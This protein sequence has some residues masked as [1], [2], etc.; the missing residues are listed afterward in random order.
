MGRLI[1]F[2]KRGTGLSDRVSPE[3]LPDLETRMDDVR[4]VL[5]A[6]G[7]RRAVVLGFSEGGSMSTLFAATHP[8]RTHALVLVGTFP[9]MMR[10]PD[11][12]I[13]HTEDVYRQ[14]FAGLDRD[15]WAQSVTK[16][17]LGRVAPDLVSDEDA[18]RWY[19]SYVMRGAS[20]AAVG[21]LWRMNQQIDIRG[22][23][24]TIAVPTLVAFRAQEYF[25]ERTRFMGEHIPGARVVELP[26]NDH[27][28]WEGDQVKLLDEVERFLSGVEE[29]V[30]PNRVLATLLFTD[31]VGSTRKA[32]ELGDRAWQ[33]LLTMHHRVVRAQLAR[34]RGHEV[35]MAGDG[36]FA[37]FDGPARAVRC[38]AAIRDGLAG[39]E[40][41]IRAGIHTGE[42]EQAD[43]GVR[44][45]AVHIA[46]RISAEA[47]GGEVLVSSTVKDIVAGSGIEFEER[48]ER[49]LHGVP[50]TWR[51]FTA[52]TPTS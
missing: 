36:V 19:I 24:P 26:G 6:V 17:W 15:D 25:G 45:I 21:A 39:L 18:V 50:G 42:I 8:D 41:E 38:A 5:D 33:E 16:E 48:G 40:L 46:A 43:G 20:P 10:A 31:L 23:L 2:D 9:R 44:G 22:V 29:D 14:R 1:L 12:P 7:S 52:I 51:L 47:S 30:E 32:A 49:E 4:A 34:F 37:T 28:P 27:L 11:F 3:R 35:D 13:G